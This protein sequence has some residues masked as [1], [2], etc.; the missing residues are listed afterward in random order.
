MLSRLFRPVVDVVNRTD[1]FPAD[2]VVH[3]VDNYFNT[4]HPIVK[5]TQVPVCA[6]VIIVLYLYYEGPC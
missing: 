4:W 5:C 1:F 2:I 6:I 3:I